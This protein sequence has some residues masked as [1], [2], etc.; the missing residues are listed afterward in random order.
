MKNQHDA[1]GWIDQKRKEFR[2]VNNFTIDFEGSTIKNIGCEAVTQPLEAFI[3]GEEKERKKT[4]LNQIK[5]RNNE[6]N[7]F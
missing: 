4:V 5:M 6:L 1:G 7:F 3:R 2:L